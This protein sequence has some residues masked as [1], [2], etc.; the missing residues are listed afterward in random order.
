M[1]DGGM[2]PRLLLV[3]DDPASRAFLIAGT[4]S[5]PADVDGAGSMQEAL[6]LASRHRYD[7]WLIDA[8]LPDGRG[9]ELL[10]R[11]RA[12]HPGPLPPA[13]GH[14]ASHLPDDLEAL[15]AAGFDV[16]ISKPL[17]IA[18][19]QSAIRHLLGQEDAAHWDD[20]LALRALNGNAAG[21]E[22]LRGLFRM[23]LPM[24]HR[25]IRDALAAGD[26][27]DARDQLHR[28]KASCGFVGAPRLRGIVDRLD[29][30]PHDVAALSAFDAEVAA[31]L[32]DAASSSS[33]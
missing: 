6:A 16:V 22:A 4:R 21:M 33:R 25:A 10:A 18:E 11:L 30:A 23:D 24:Q 8:R 5:L 26:V 15:R 20:A 12:L 27:G 14:T 1:R 31:L 19:W 13:L 7:A 9:A 17:P 32:E 3:E 29:A 28:L 2:N